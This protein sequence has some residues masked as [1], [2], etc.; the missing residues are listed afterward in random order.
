MTHN[1]FPFGDLPEAI[2]NQIRTQ[3]DQQSMSQQVEDALIRAMVD[4]L[5]AEGI[6]GLHLLMETVVDSREHGLILIGQLRE[7]FAQRYPNHCLAHGMVHDKP[8]GEQPD[9]EA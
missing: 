3:M 5:D 6:A 1:I 2:Q 4:G 8:E 7:R 9:V